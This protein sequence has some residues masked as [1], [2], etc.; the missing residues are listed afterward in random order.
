MQQK[1]AGMPTLIFKCNQFWSYVLPPILYPDG[2]VYLKLGGATNVADPSVAAANGDEVP[3]LP[4][5]IILKTHAQVSDWYKGSG[6]RALLVQ[7]LKMVSLLFPALA[8]VIA[9]AGNVVVDTCCTTHTKTKQL[10]LDEVAPGLTVVAGGNGYAA[11]SADEIGKVAC[12]VALGGRPPAGL[13]P[14]FVTR[15]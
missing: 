9:D 5:K 3:L 12:T 4:G 10:Y 2:C 15:S 13:M 1:F 8:P 14:Q 6:S 11:K 7:Q